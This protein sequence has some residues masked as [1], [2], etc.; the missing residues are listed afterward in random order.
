MSARTPCAL[1]IAGSDSS[2]GA[3]LQADLKTFS[4]LGVYGA[5]AITAITAQNTLGV[6]AVHLVPGSIVAAQIDAVF[7][8]LAISAVKTGMLGGEES[9]LAVSDRLERWA[10]GVPIVVDPVLVSTTGSRLLERGA[11]LALAE[12]LIP[13]AALLTPNRHEAAVLLNS[14]IALS[15]GDAKLQAERLLTLGPGA[16]LLKGGHDEGPEAVDLFF[17]GEKFRIY[18]A[19][20]IQT[21]NTHGTGCTLA[22]A[23]AAFLVKGYSLEEAVEHAKTYLH[24]ALERSED[25]N[26]GAGSGPVSHFYRHVAAPLRTDNV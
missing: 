12:R 2:A 25:L 7:S 14:D 3:G 4:A 16:V 8:D 24:G 21:K 17:D 9:I 13:Q 18:A 11:E 22:S 10:S 5:T 26:V 1:S 6:T 15:E 23:I 19:P 20:R